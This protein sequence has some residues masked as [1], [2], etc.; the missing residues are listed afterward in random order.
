MKLSSCRH[1]RSVHFKVD[2]AAPHLP[3]QSLTNCDL[4][5]A[6]YAVMTVIVK[7]KATN[8]TFFSVFQVCMFAFASIFTVVYLLFPLQN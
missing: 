6:S 8:I 2:A 4:P 3:A 7:V 1:C 5:S